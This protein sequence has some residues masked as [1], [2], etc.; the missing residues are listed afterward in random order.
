MATDTPQ[1][2]Q[3]TDKPAD[4]KQKTKAVAD[5]LAK[6]KEADEKDGGLNIYNFR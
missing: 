4:P 1:T 5:P 2:E 6:F 3:P